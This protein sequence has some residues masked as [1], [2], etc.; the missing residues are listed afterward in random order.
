MPLLA[1]DRALEFAVTA[2]LQDAENPVLTTAELHAHLTRA[3][4]QCPD[5]EDLFT[6][7]AAREKRFETD[8]ASGRVAL[9]VIAAPRDLRILCADIG[10][11]TARRFAW[12]GPDP[13]DHP[14]TWHL[15]PEGMAQQILR[16]VGDGAAVAVGFECPTWA[17]VPTTQTDLGKARPGEGARSWSA[18]AGAQVLATGLVQISWILEHVA[19][20]AP[21]MRAYLDWHEFATADGP[22]L[23]LWEAF[24]TGR[25]K[26][27][28]HQ[29]DA[30]LAARAF[31]DALPDPR[32]SL[33]V[34][35]SGRAISL[36]GAAALWA[37]LSH[38]T[39]LLHQSALVIG[40]REPTA[41]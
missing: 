38:D 40:P 9:R 28:S 21:S 14:Q 29:D 30:H 1:H 33:S 37:T 24:V 2:A 13:H 4:V 10:S 16:F 8:A 20:E 12:A 36:L 39:T 32:R 41:A 26:G 35:S 17:P 23:F 31:A 5:F 22:R 27:A 18:G 7:C 15:H 19:A 34:R 6:F 25:A 3:G 11:L